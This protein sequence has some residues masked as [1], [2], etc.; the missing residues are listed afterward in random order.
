[1]KNPASWEKSDLFRNLQHALDVELWTIPLY[2]TALYSIRNLTNLKHQEYPEAAKL[3][4]SVV[5][6]EMLHAELVCNL[7]NA[8]GYSPKFNFPEYDESK[9]IPFIHPAAE[10]LPKELI[11]YQVKPQ[12]LNKESLQLFCAIEL[13]HPKKETDWENINEYTSIA[14]LYEAI[15]ISLT[16]LWNTCYIGEKLNKK[17]KN[18]FLEYCNVD[19]KNHGFS[20]IINSLD[21]ALK[22]IEAI[23]EQGEGADSRHVHIDFR[24]PPC[25]EGEDFDT[26]W[27]RGNL[28]HYQKFRIL[29]H[30][31]HKLPPVYNEYLSEI[32]I[33]VNK[34]MKTAFLDFWTEMEIGFNQAGQD[35]NIDFWEKMYP[36]SYL[37]AEV[38]QEGMCPIFN[39]D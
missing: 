10:S 39:S 2:M 9:G 27:Y 31:Y 25:P 20:I 32:S 35:M 15:K 38:W 12:A 34:K 19:G 30:S 24:P 21:A 13:P 18:T 16:A 7:S 17:Q 3:I 22:A 6:Q 14:D 26:A 23:I 5:V 36:L 1:M 4:L 33:S 37:L 8:V 11:G 29:L 28:S